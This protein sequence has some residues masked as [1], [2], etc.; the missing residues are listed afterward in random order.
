[1]SDHPHNQPV[2]EVFLPTYRTEPG[3][4]EKC[5]L[6]HTFMS[7]ITWKCRFYPSQARAIAETVVKA[8]LDGQ[9][10]DESDARA[11]SVDIGN[12]VREAVTGNEICAHPSV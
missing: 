11:W 12:K 7:L 9:V 4:S 3:E 1:M 5:V 6:M 8:E 2:I 10:Y